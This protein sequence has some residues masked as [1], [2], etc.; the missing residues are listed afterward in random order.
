MMEMRLLGVNAGL[1]SVY[2]KYSGVLEM[3]AARDSVTKLFEMDFAQNPELK[4]EYLSEYI[5]SIPRKQR[6]DLAQSE[7]EKLETEENLTQR[8]LE[9]LSNGFK[10]L[11]D[12]EKSEK[13]YEIIKE[14][15]PTSRLVD[16]K[17]YVRYRNMLRV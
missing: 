14:K 17:F 10:G 4:R 9:T 11:G 2:S 15:Y 16:S 7:L 3:L 6:T 8:D 13:Y 1:A 12:H 5:N